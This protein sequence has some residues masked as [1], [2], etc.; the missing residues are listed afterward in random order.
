MAAN[1]H[2]PAMKTGKSDF[3]GFIVKEIGEPIRQAQG[4]LRRAGF[5]LISLISLF[6]VS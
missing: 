4:R 2:T 5:L 3:V 1:S 6:L